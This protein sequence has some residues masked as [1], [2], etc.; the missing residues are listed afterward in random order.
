MWDLVVVGGGPAGATLARLASRHHRVLLLE[1]RRPPIPGGAPPAKVCGGLLAPD[2]QRMLATLGLGVPR[3]VLCGP[4]LFSVR[5]IDAATGLERHYQRS[6][7]NVDRG[8]LDRW[9]LDL[10]EPG[11][12]VRRGC[13]LRRLREEADHVLLEVESVGGLSVERAR[14]VAGA[15]GAL[16][17]VR[18][19]A[20]PGR[21]D[22]DLYVAIQERLAARGGEACFTAIFEPSA[23]DFYGWAI[24]KDGELVVG[25]AV[26]PGAAAPAA[27][28]RMKARLAA[29]GVATG[30]VRAREGALLRRPR[31]RD[32]VLGR[33]GVALLGEAAG[34]VSPSSAEGISWA[35][36][37]A[38]ALADA[39]EPGI[40]GW[41]GRYRAATASLRRDLVLKRLKMPF[42]YW[43]W[44]RALALAS[45]AGAVRVRAR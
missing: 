34:F 41:E 26:R 17:R 28:E 44:L 24:P 29:F 37:S 13:R 23:G 32:L 20:F 11:A 30:P 8:R 40:F 27:F 18:R 31:R 15:D 2:A 22:G 45:G 6:Y 5:A 1:A 16:S 14:L 39:L 19:H 12:V 21:P 43:P 42:M 38:A 4:Q 7:L 25:A 35:L 3:A 33:G 10:A 9:L 36:R